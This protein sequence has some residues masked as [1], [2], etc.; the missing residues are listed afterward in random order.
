[1]DWGGNWIIPWKT[2]LFSN[3]FPSQGK[4]GKK[5]HDN[6]TKHQQQ[7]RKCNINDIEVSKD[8]SPH[9]RT[10]VSIPC[11]LFVCVMSRC[12]YLPCN[13]FDYGRR[14]FCFSND[15]RRRMRMKG[16]QVDFNAYSFSTQEVE[17]SVELLSEFVLH[18]LPCVSSWPGFWGTFLY[19][20]AVGKAR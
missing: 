3:C 19:S 14:L 15:V 2:W 7:W 8:S 9:L 6:N 5:Q 10:C 20:I 1:M 11:V 17:L 16:T 12:V 18:S 13:A 4:D